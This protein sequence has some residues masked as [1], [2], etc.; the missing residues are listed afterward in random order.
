MGDIKNR[1]PWGVFSKQTGG[2]LASCA[3]EKRARKVALTYGV[4]E[5]DCFVPRIA[6]SS[7]V[8]GCLIAGFTG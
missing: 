7:F 5:Q 1:A 8:T 2:V 3:S 4:S 6:S